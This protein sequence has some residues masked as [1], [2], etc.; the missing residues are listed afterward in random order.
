MKLTNYGRKEWLRATVCAALLLV[1][2][3]VL[4]VIVNAQAGLCLAVFVLVMW[5]AFA[6]FFRDPERKTPAGEKLLTSPADGVVRDIELIPNSNC[7]N[8]E[9]ATLFEGRDMLRIGIFLSV[10]DVHLNRAPCR[11]TVKFTSYKEGCFHDARDERAAKENESMIL[12]GTGVIEGNEFPVAVKQISGAVARRIVCPVEPGTVLEKGER[13]GMIKFGSRTELYLPVK[14]NFTPAVSVG[15]RV[16]GG[17][18]VIARFCVKQ[19][20]VTGQKT[21]TKIPS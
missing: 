5:T 13:Y 19:D 14:S 15:D 21:Q 12:G 18:T 3:V 17:T 20:T 7:G 2:C 6:A 9:L 11:M 1:L 10:F 8:E 16:F 4:A